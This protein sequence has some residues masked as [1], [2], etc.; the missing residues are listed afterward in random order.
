MPLVCARYGRYEPPVRREAQELR[1]QDQLAAARAVVRQHH[2]A[3]LVE[4]QFRRHPAEAR[5][6]A[7]QPL[8]QHRHGL[9][10]IE[11]Q[12]QQPRMGE[13]LHQRVAPAPWQRERAEVHL[14]LAA[15][16][17]EAHR[18]LGRIA[19]PNLVT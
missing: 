18:R 8:G 3:H 15:R 19:R 9:P 14:A 7:L 17:L 10:R 2:R 12:P 4:Q 1:V 16:R 5:E 13:H 11:P 6:R